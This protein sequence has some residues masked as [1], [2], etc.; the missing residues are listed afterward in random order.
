MGN[1]TK[2]RELAL[3]ALYFMDM[4]RDISKEMLDLFCHSFSQH[5]KTIPFFRQ[6]ANGVME[7]IGE[8][9][10]VIERYSSHWKI[11]R[12]TCVDRN[13]LRIATYEI[14]YCDDIPSKVSINEAVNIGKRFGTRESGGF[15]NGVLDSMRIGEKPDKR[16]IPKKENEKAP[17]MSPDGEK[18]PDDTV[19]ILPEQKTAPDMAI[20]VPPEIRIL[21]MELEGEFENWPLEKVQ[22]DFFLRELVENRGRYRFKKRGMKAPAGTVVLFQFGDSI[23]A[24]AELRRIER[25]SEPESSEYRGAFDFDP[26][27]INVFKPLGR[28][29]MRSV[30]SEDWEDL[31]GEWH[32]G[33]DKFGR[34]MQYLEPEKLTELYKQ[35]KN[36]EQD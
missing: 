24:L 16:H 7:S 22:N 26:S 13:V 32:E 3:Q 31:E 18:P 23:I 9:D 2:A 29:V 33:F 10:V 6:L 1:R 4:R 35:L 36:L 8:I 20:R 27:T 5:P 34:S 30:F 17:G 28:D 11:S 14:L 19:D 21:P 12:M 15:I 25:F